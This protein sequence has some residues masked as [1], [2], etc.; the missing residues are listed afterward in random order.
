MV[1]HL[2]QIVDHD[3]KVS[4]SELEWCFNFPLSLSSTC[5][6]LRIVIG[7]SMNKVQREESAVGSTVDMLDLNCKLESIVP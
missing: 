3:R 1:P 7:T 2:F 4:N 5:G 6:G